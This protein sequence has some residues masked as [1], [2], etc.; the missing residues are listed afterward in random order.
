[1]TMH[2]GQYKYKISVDDITYGPTDE[3]ELDPLL[4]IVF[5]KELMDKGYRRVSNAYCHIARIDRDDWLTV[6]AKER[7]CS[8]ADFYSVDGSGVSDSHRDHYCRVHSKDTLTVHPSI[9]RKIPAF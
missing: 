5:A 3:D 4:A 6:L 2:I 8:I 7:C 1:M 9:L